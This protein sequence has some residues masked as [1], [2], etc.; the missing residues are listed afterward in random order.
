MTATPTPEAPLSRHWALVG[1]L[2]KGTALT[3]EGLHGR[4]EH[5]VSGKADLF[6]SLEALGAFRAQGLAVQGGDELPRPAPAPEKGGQQETCEMPEDFLLNWASLQNRRNL[7]RQAVS[8]L[9]VI[10]CEAN[11]QTRVT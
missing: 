1:Q 3:P 7:V 2:R 5:I 6:T 8:P 11:Q 9:V 10:S 4:V